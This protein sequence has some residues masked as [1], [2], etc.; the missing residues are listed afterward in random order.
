MNINLA[1]EITASEAC[2]YIGRSTFIGRIEEFSSFYNC[3]IVSEYFE[4]DDGHCIEHTVR[5][6]PAPKQEQEAYF[7]YD[8]L[9]PVIF[10]LIHSENKDVKNKAESLLR[11]TLS[12]DGKKDVFFP[13]DISIMVDGLAKKIGCSFNSMVIIL[14]ALGL[15][16]ENEVVSFMEENDRR[17]IIS[18]C[19]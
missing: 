19:L 8:S 10:A 15:I 18:H 9:Y 16:S 3:I 12:Y 14:I 11:K 13:K 5:T 17:T 6:Y 7:V 2:C 1:K 4:S